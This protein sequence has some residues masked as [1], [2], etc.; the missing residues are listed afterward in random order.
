MKIT[1]FNNIVLAEVI[2]EMDEMSNSGIVLPDRQVGRFIKI[3]ILA[4]GDKVDSPI[5]V[6]DIC[7]ANALLEALDP[8][9]SKVGFINSKDILGRI[10]N[11]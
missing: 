4:M 3:K 1:P 8:K 7:L 9:N 5:K 2:E 11:V 10:E 6:N